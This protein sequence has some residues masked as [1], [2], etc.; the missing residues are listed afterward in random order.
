MNFVRG[1]PAYEWYLTQD[2]STAEGAWPDM[3]R[4]ANNEWIV[5][6]GEKWCRYP[7]CL[8]LTTFGDTNKLKYYINKKYMNTGDTMARSSGGSPSLALL[9]E[10]ND[11]FYEK[12][13]M[14]LKY[15]FNSCDYFE[16]FSEEESEEDNEE[17]SNH[18]RDSDT[19][20]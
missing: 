12:M 5:Y 19:E 7:G 11:D 13:S 4:N 3:T 10:A 6:P 20:E 1:Q 8:Y 9:R 18:G 16:Y 17:D 2:K 14:R 15:V